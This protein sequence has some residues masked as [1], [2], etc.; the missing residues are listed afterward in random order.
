MKPALILS[1]VA[2]MAFAV[3]RPA[4]ADNPTTIRIGVAQPAVGNPPGIA[5]STL[6]IAHAKDWRE[7]EFKRDNIKVEWFFFKG[8]GPAVN[9]ALT[10]DQ[11]DFAL[12]GDLP[13]IIGRA[14]G[15]K[16]KVILATSTR[17]NIYLAVP[18]DSPIKTPKDIRGKRVAFFKGTWTVAYQSFSRSK[19]FDREGYQGHQ[20]GYRYFAGGIDDQGC[21]GCIRRL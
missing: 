4:F 8:A 7:E 14:G 5:G 12:Q 15:L 2:F 13:S 10:N 11:L 9:E 20:S 17:A 1:A 6:A 18:P 21:R 19:R 16:T 3:F